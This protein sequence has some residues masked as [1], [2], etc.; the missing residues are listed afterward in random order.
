MH[1]RRE[2]GAVH[3]VGVGRTGNGYAIPTKDAKVRTLPLP[4]IKNYVLDFL[5]YA[6]AHPDLRFEVTRIGCG[7]AG[8]TDAQMA[9]MFADAPANCY[10]PHGWRSN[11]SFV[12]EA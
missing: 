6:K 4:E 12:R 7:L 10:L 11:L 2:H 3:G 1:A 8:Y 9:P 5:R